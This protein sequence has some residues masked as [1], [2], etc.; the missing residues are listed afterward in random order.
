VVIMLGGLAG[1]YFFVQRHIDATEQNDAARSFGST[2]TFGE[3]LGSTYRNLIEGLSGDFGTDSGAP[4]EVGHAAPRLWRVSAAPVAGMGFMGTTSS[5]YFAERAT[6]N[7]LRAS[8]ERSAILRLTN[9]LMPKVHE[10]LFAEDGSVILR[11]ADADDRATTFAAT[12]AS[13]TPSLDSNSSPQTLKGVYLPHDIVSIVAL[14]DA[15]QILYLMENPAG[16]VVGVTAKW[17]GTRQTKIYESPLSEWRLTS[18]EDGAAVLAQK[19]SDDVAGYSFMLKENG[20]VTSLIGNMPG[21]TVL[22]RT[23]GAR[24]YSISSGGTRTLFVQAS[25]SAAPVS[26]PIRTITD[27]C[28]WRK[29]AD[30]VAYCAVPRAAEGDN[31]LRDWYRGA[32]HTADAWWVINASAGT[33]ELLYTP[34]HEYGLDVRDPAID[35]SG[36]YLAFINGVD[37]SLWMLRIAE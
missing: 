6:G 26:L 9:T 37:R 2:P 14:R 22:P 35:E 11:F 25:P 7:V 34:P 36:A 30:L 29:G 33:V 20:T 17:D 18:F 16:G 3:S 28:V 19:A 10:A 23:S 21:L 8:P 5:L 12:L 4:E 24:L 15:S 27:K 13:T 32:I 31:F 1:W